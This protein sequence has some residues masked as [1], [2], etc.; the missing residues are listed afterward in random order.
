[1]RFTVLASGSRG[2][3]AIVESGGFRVLIDCGLSL[4]ELTRRMQAHSI[5]PDN[6]DALL[7]THFH[8]DHIRGIRALLQSVTV[9]VY[10][11]RGFQYLDIPCEWGGLRAE[12][13]IKLGPLIAVPLT[14]PHDDGGT[15]GFVF[16]DCAG[17]RFVFATDL[18]SPTSDLADAIASADALVIE[19]NH[20]LQ[21][22]ESCSYPDFIKRR[23]RSELGHLSN[24]QCSELLE[25]FLPDSC[26]T[27]VLAHLS[28]KAND[29]RSA[30]KAMANVVG[31]R[32]HAASQHVPSGWIEIGPAQFSGVS[33]VG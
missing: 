8:S 25:K 28:E 29:P 3:A 17:K 22:L 7:I 9:P 13:S 23:I 20:C 2:N 19:S 12:H 11:P 15:F 24:C 27:V 4:R 16:D 5:S 21:L 33:A 31:R 18:G 30:L 1:M 26:E 10:A 32:L 14:L 6:I